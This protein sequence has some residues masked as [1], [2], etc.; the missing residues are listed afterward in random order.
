M[1]KDREYM[2]FGGYGGDVPIK[3]PLVKSGYT[4]SNL[5]GNRCVSAHCNG[6]VHVVY[7]SEKGLVSNGYCFWD[8]L[9]YV[10][11]TTMRGSKGR[12]FHLKDGKL[13]PFT[14][15]EDELRDL[16][17]LLQNPKENI[18]RINLLLKSKARKTK[19]IKEMYN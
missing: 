18:K 17:A 5:K 6:Q 4:N 12:W 13:Q 16:K 14:R 9:S 7:I 15:E 1:P 19:I 8:A 11:R 3:L 10:T 2:F